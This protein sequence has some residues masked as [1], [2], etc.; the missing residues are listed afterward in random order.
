MVNLVGME[1]FAPVAADLRA[2]L[3]AWIDR[4]EGGPPPEIVPAP[5]RPSR[6][7]RLDKRTL[8]DEYARDTRLGMDPGS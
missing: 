3:L 7:H 1:P 2:R 6:Q 5:P 8:R 4:I